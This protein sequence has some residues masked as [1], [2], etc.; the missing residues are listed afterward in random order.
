MQRR[1]L[2]H[3]AVLSSIALPA[4]AQSTWPTG[5]TINYVVPFP[6]GGTTDV[7]GRLIAQ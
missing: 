7:L 6:A 3:A 5:K 4:F 2:I 1:T